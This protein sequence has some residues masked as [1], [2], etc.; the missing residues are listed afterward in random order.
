MASDF[1]KKKAFSISEWFKQASSSTSAAVGTLLDF[2][3]PNGQGHETNDLDIT[4][5]IGDLDKVKPVESCFDV[6]M[7]ECSY[8]VNPNSTTLIS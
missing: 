1:L 2:D 4:N 8:K 6:M 3:T 5:W 7:D